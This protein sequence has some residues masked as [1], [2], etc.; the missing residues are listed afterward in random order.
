MKRYLPCAVSGFLAVVTGGYLHVYLRPDTM[1]YIHGESWFYPS[2]LGRLLGSVGGYSGMVLASGIAAFFLPQVVGRIAE[3]NGRNPVSAGWKALLF[4]AA[5]FMFPASVDP[6]A[7]LLVL[8]AL[9]VSRKASSLVLLALGVLL[10]L[11]IM[12]AA[13]AIALTRFVRGGIATFFAASTCIALGIAYLVATPYGAL[14]SNHVN[15]SRFLLGGIL[16]FGVGVTPVLW[17]RSNREIDRLFVAG[18]IV[19]AFGACEAAIQQHFQIRYC[20]PGCLILAAACSPLTRALYAYAEDG[21]RHKTPA[22]A[23]GSQ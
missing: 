17:A 19:V 14:V 11:A 12:P 22:I 18:I 8:S 7:A 16:T 23:G 10:H 20:L 5:W 4:P 15:F 9:A 3:D 1:L 21:A 2:P 13:L 6:L